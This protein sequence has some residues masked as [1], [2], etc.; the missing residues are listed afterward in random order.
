V[1]KRGDNNTAALR[2]AV[3]EAQRQAKLTGKTGE[4]EVAVPSLDAS[5]FP[6]DRTAYYNTHTEDA[7]F[8]TW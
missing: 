7:G 8:R 4:I 5:G 1:A 2:W 6:C 3:G